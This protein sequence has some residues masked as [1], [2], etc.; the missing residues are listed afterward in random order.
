MIQYI[1]CEFQYGHT[2]RFYIENIDSIFSR[3]LDIN[4]TEIILPGAGEPGFIPYGYIIIE[5]DSITSF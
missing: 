4:G 5:I 1:S 3:F 2:G